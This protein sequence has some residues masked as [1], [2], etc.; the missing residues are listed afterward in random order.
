MIKGF[1]FLG[2]KLQKKRGKNKIL[3]GYFFVITF[4]NM[5]FFM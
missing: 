3:I 1:K 4:G 5:I 2:A